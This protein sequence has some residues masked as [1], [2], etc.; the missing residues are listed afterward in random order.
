MTNPSDMTDEQLGQH[1]EAT[2]LDAPSSASFN[3]GLGGSERFA[4]A[5]A[6]V[7]LSALSPAMREPIIEKLNK[8]PI[9]MQAS[10]EKRLVREALEQNSLDFRIQTGV[11]DHANAYQRET[12]DIAQETYSLAQHEQWILDQLSATDGHDRETGKPISSVQGP[13]REAL[14]HELDRTG[15]AIKQ[16][17]GPER[18]KRLAKAKEQAIADHRAHQQRLADAKEVDRRADE[19]NREKRIQ[20]QA[21]AKAAWKDDSL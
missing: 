1:I 11:S 10:E 4:K 6:N 2:R 8:L 16:L 19:I 14:Q 15:Y 9:S 12:F 17:N 7:G 3:G 5:A 20:K 21:E 18:E 13:R